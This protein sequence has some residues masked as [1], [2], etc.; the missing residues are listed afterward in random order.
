M[1]AQL[2]CA[3]HWAFQDIP[4]R[5]GNDGTITRFGWKAQNKS[6][7]SFA[8]EAY[9]VEVGITNEVFPTATEED[10]ACQGRQKPEPND[11]TRTDPDDTRNQA[12]ENPVHILPDWMQFQVM[13]RF[14]DGPAPDPNPSDSAKRGKDIFAKIGCSL[15][16]T[17]EMQT[18]PTMNS[19]VLQDRPVNLYSDLLLHHMGANLADDIVQGQAGPD[20]FRTTP[21]WGVGQR[22]FFIHDGRTSDLMKAI[23]AHASQATPQYPGLE[24]NGVIHKF[25]HL[26]PQDQQAILT[27][28][29]SLTT[30]H[31]IAVSGNP[32]DGY[33]G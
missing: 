8:G 28:L 7:P 10:P 25:D 30:P 17:Q 26:T 9:N 33:L 15:C 3:L 20:E 18:A 22:I 23:R 14:T 12:F 16:H 21:L 4:I 1:T 13:M 31:N 29:S 6:S 2:P 11:V 24:A 5:S 32:G 19:A 27:F